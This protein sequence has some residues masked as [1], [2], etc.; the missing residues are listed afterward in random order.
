MMLLASLLREIYLPSRIEVCRGYAEA[1]NTTVKT[2]SAQLGHP[3]TLNDFTE[4]SISAYLV[5]YRVNWSAR[6]TNNQRAN[7]VTLWLSA[8]DAGLVEKMPRTRHIRKLKTNPD[9]PL[10]WTRDNITM[11]L[12]FCKTLD[13][14]L[15]GVP[16]TQWW[17]ALRP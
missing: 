13:G 12:Q 11:L 6:S 15:C 5:A 14:D 9:P 2:F 10:A 3:A 8:F 1:M 17:R 4:P 7:L 16:A